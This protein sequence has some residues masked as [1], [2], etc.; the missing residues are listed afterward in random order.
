[1]NL[2]IN[3]LITAVAAFV[4]GEYVLEG[5]S[6]TG[7]ESALIFAV[8]FGIVNAIVKPILTTL[9]IP[10]TIITLGLFSLVINALMVLLVDYLM[11]GMD[12]VNFWWALGFSILLSIITSVLGG[13]FGTKS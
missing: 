5:V 2:L 7:F 12:V 13:I 9:T 8:I 11:D 1:M 6:F 4:L 10:I 3:L